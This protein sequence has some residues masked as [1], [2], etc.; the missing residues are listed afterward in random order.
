LLIGRK[1]AVPVG[2]LLFLNLAIF[3]AMQVNYQYLDIKF[4][5]TAV[6]HQLSWND[7]FGNC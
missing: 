2:M 7:C 3:Y 4:V 6:Q 1:V 5:L